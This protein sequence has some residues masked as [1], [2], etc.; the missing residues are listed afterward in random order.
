M[1]LLLA[2]TLALS[3]LSEPA[4]LGEVLHHLRVLYARAM[5]AAPATDSIAHALGT[6]S[7]AASSSGSLHAK[8]KNIAD[9]P[10]S[11]INSI[12]RGTIDTS[13]S[14]SVVTATATIT[15]VNTAKA[16]L[17]W[18]GSVPQ[19]PTNNG[20][21]G[22]ATLTNATTVTAEGMGGGTFTIR[23]GY[24]VVEYK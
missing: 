6:R 17:S 13:V 15:S 9:N 14:G 16:F 7:D 19:V 10:P 5:P 2:L 3:P 4:M 20:W 1:R 11:V 23:H 21:G 22:R 8:V 18:V 12:Q 24:E